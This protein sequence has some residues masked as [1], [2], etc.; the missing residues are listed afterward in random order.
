MT[1]RYIDVFRR[2]NSTC[3]RYNKPY[4]TQLCHFQIEGDKDLSYDYDGGDYANDDAGGDDAYQLE[5]G[6]R[7]QE[8]QLC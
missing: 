7:Q 1:I 5:R 8:G 6:S 3:T 4:L 2:H